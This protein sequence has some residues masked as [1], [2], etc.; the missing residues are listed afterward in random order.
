MNFNMV[1]AAM[2]SPSIESNDEDYEDSLVKVDVD[3][4][5][6]HADMKFVLFWQS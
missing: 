6:E 5:D 3:D 4:E 1:N 2:H